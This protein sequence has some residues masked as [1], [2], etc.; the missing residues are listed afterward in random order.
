M[1]A[2]C[3]A[4]CEQLSLVAPTPPHAVRLAAVALT[5]EGLTGTTPSV[6]PVRAALYGRA[7][8]LRL[9]GA[10]LPTHQG[11]ID[12]FREQVGPAMILLGFDE[13][14]AVLQLDGIYIE[15]ADASDWG[16]RGVLLRP[17][18]HA[19]PDSD[20]WTAEGLRH[21]AT[22]T[23]QRLDAQSVN[24]TV[25]ADARG[26]AHDLERALRHAHPDRGISA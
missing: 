4:L 11:E 5:L 18:P 16:G 19:I 12:H 3:H 9:G 14:H 23:Y 15:V 17:F 13:P 2:L 10:H 8:V 24:L 26:L 21:G 20:T 7:A 6:V 22:I 25:D 1:I